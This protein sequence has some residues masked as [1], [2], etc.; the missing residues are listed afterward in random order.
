MVE[1]FVSSAGA[2]LHYASWNVDLDLKLRL[3]FSASIPGSGPCSGNAKRP[4]NPIRMFRVSLLFALL[5]PLANLCC[6]HDEHR[7]WKSVL[8]RGQLLCFSQRNP[9]YCAPNRIFHP[10]ADKIG[11]FATV[12]DLE[13]CGRSA[14]ADCSWQACGLLGGQDSLVHD[15][16]KGRHDQRT[17]AHGLHWVLGWVPN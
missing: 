6:G 10:N 8:L 1:L 15:P 17:S 3:Y 2:L 14:Q 16:L 9:A 4:C 7:F 13:A 12:Q 5:G 11:S